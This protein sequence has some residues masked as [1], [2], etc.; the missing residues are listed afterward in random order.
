M[1]TLDNIC[2]FVVLISAG[3]VLFYFRKTKRPVPRQSWG[4]RAPIVILVTAIF[5]VYITNRIFW[6]NSEGIGEVS[7]TLI[8]VVGAISIYADYKCSPRL[9]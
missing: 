3:V 2:D 8:C 1:G 7:R 6:M 4:T 9:Q 5:G